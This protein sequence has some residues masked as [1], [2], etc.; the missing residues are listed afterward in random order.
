M[1]A[2]LKTEEKVLSV[3][4]KLSMNQGSP[5]VEAPKVHHSVK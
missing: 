3:R 2:K 1:M 5:K 4:E